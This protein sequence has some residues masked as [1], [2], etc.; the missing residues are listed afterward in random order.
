MIKPSKPFIFWFYVLLFILLVGVLAVEIV[1]MYALSKQ[2]DTVPNIVLVLLIASTALV[3][4][5]AVFFLASYNPLR[6]QERLNQ[7]LRKSLDDQKEAAQAKEN[8]LSVISHEIRTPLNSVIGLTNLLLKRNPREDQV[9]VVRTLK[10]SADNLMHLVSDI[11]DFNKIQAG[12]LDLEFGGFSFKEFLHQLHAMFSTAADDKGLSFIVKSDPR[13]PDAL[14]GDVN[15]L[16]QIF[17]NLLSNAIKFTNKGEVSL[18][19]DFLGI[20]NDACRISFVIRDTGIGIPERSVESI[21]L[22]FQQANPEVSRKYGGTGLGLTIV[23]SLV[24]MLN[25][26]ISM[27]SLPNKGSVFVVELEFPIA[28]S[29]SAASSPE[30]RTVRGQTLVRKA[31][32]LYVEDVDSN[33][34]LVKNLLNHQGH[35]CFTAS[36]GSEALNLTQ[37]EKFDIILMDIHMADMDGY[38]TTRAIRNQAIGF[39]VKTPIIAFTAEPISEK[40]KSKTLETDIQDVMSKPFAPETLYE[41]IELYTNDNFHGQRMISFAFYEYAFDHDANQ[42]I[43]IRAAILEDLKKFE[44]SFLKCNEKQDLLGMREALHRI[45]PI[46]KNLKGLDLILLFDNFRM[47]ETYSP[48]IEPLVNRIQKMAQEIMVQVSSFRFGDE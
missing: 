42:L 41:K 29:P 47:Y 28:D 35:T 18:E 39:N 34:F 36:S 27:T 25:G 46:V 5:G 17:N 6:T 10:S 2:K 43:E 45:R 38:Q 8:F 44:T 26:K 32:V 1:V 13:I 16:H 9:E 15:R 31:K 12:K 3:I 4:L 30:M 14:I 22:P 7:V 40:L 20:A 21:F 33:R 11:L 19:A 24:Q 48:E 23:K 37:S